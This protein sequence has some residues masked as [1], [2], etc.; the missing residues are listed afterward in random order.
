[1][2]YV[3]TYQLTGKFSRSNLLLPP[4]IP[5]RPHLNE[6]LWRQLHFGFG[7]LILAR[8]P[9]DSRHA[10]VHRVRDIIRICIGARDCDPA[11]RHECLVLVNRHPREPLNDRAMRATSEAEKVALLEPAFGAA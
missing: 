11:L 5:V 4:R 7:R 2:T 10:L 3:R 8:P 9:G 6:P 1:M